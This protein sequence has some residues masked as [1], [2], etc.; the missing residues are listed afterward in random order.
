MEQYEKDLKKRQETP[1]LIA[2]KKK[3][4]KYFERF[5]KNDICLLSSCLSIDFIDDPFWTKK[6]PRKGADGKKRTFVFSKIAEKL[7]GRLLPYLNISYEGKMDDSSSFD[8]DD[9]SS[10]THPFASTGEAMPESDEYFHRLAEN[11]Q[12]FDPKTIKRDLEEL[13]YNELLDYRKV[14]KKKIHIYTKEYR[15]KEDISFESYFTSLCKLV[16]AADNAFW[17]D[18]F[19]EFPI[20]SFAND[21]FRNVPAT[22]IQVDKLFSL[23]GCIA[24]KKISNL[25]DSMFESL[26]VLKSFSQTA[27]ISAVDLQ[28]CT[29]SQAI[30]ST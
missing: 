22:S 13:I 29:L 23:A 30:N 8:E 11:I 12:N 28:K 16:I 5:S 20:L 21:I 25:S 4:D 6:F 7:S 2:F 1:Y 15:Q 19:D 17:D 26:C 14:T 18:H 3:M 10:T 9:S 24:T 27:D